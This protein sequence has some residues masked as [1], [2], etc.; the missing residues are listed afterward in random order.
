MPRFRIFL[1]AVTSEFGRARD[2]VAADLRSRETLLRA[3]SDFRQEAG[4]VTRPFGSTPW[5]NS[6][7]N[8]GVEF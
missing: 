6:P 4:M 7:E 3:Q 1:S 2:A 5:Q 8:V